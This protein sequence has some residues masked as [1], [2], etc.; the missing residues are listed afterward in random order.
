MEFE[1]WVSDGG[2]GGGDVM[3]VGGLIGDSEDES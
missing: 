1:G 3:I 2:G